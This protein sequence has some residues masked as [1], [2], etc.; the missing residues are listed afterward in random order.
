MFPMPNRRRDHPGLRKLDPEV[1]LGCDLAPA[2]P[3]V[4]PQ[5]LGNHP[6]SPF[7]FASEGKIERRAPGCPGPAA[8]APG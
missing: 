7:G 2:C 3:M 1:C 4:F 6:A 5:C 8:Q